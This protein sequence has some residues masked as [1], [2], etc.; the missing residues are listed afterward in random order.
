MDQ[1]SNQNRT[2]SSSLFV[3]L[4][5]ATIGLVISLALLEIAFRLVARGSKSTWSDRAT[6]YFM[7]ASAPSMQDRGYTQ[8]KPAG[9][10]RIGIV[11][12]SFTFGPRLQYD[13]TFSKRI[14][15]WLNLNKEQPLVEVLNF[16]V[17]GSSTRDEVVLVNQALEKNADLVILQITLNDAE[18]HILSKEERQ[19]LFGAAFLKWPIFRYWKS[20]GFLASRFHNSSTYRAYIKYHSQFW[21]NPDSFKVFEDSVKRMQAACAEVHKP[22]IAVLFPLFDFPFNDRYPLLG[23]HKKIDDTLATLAIPH[24][25]LLHAYDGIPNER[26]QVVPGD[27][28]HPNEIAHRIAAEQIIEFLKTNSL[29][30][31]ESYPKRVYPQRINTKERMKRST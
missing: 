25:D 1:S 11:G 3:N 9:A 19:D 21:E 12:D 30:P 22:F 20:L 16:G 10:F 28:N 2:R 4:L 13:D 6:S 26:M 14:E 7:P 17:S 31:P 24:L 23:V 8:E 5:I 29:L 18:P 15:R 27:D